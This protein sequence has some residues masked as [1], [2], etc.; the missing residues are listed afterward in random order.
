MD[1]KNLSSRQIR[2]AQELSCYYICI[3]YYQGKANKATDALFRYPQQSQSKEKILH[4][5]NTRIFQHLQS[6][7]INACASS[8]LPAYVASLKHVIICKTHALPDICQSW[9]TFCQELAA[10]CPY[11]ASI[12]GMKLRL[13]EL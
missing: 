10:K 7:L 12:R 4:T 1:T 6:L 3:N 8:T 11:Q 2:W 5:E 9:K 13:L